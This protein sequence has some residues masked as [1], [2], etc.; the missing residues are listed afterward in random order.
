MTVMDSTVSQ[1][2]MTL[3]GLTSEPRPPPKLRSLALLCSN[4]PVPVP[5][6]T[7][8]KQNRPKDPLLI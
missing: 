4:R 8:E 6:P 2:G 7:V 5:L 1:N 3:T